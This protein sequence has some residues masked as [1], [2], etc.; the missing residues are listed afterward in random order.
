MNHAHSG[1]TKRQTGE[2]ETD[3]RRLAQIHESQSEDSGDR[4]GNG[5][6]DERIPTMGSV[7][8]SLYRF[9]DLIFHATLRFRT[10]LETVACCA[11]QG[12]LPARQRRPH[13][14]RS[15]LR[16]TRVACRARDYSY[17]L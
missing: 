17:A 3:Q 11:R 2:N 4:Y 10:I 9:N 15:K 13:L 5:N 14:M 1:W 6:A 7:T 12:Q 16:E 8:H